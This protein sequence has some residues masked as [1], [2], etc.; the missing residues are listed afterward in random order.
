LEARAVTD[1]DFKDDR[2]KAGPGLREKPTGAAL[3]AA[4]QASPYREAALQPERY[5]MP[6]REAPLMD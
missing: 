3:V 5:P 4:V 2:K 1:D 6:V